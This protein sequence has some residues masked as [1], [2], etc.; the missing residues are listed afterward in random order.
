MKVSVS[1]LNIQK[2]TELIVMSGTSLKELP[3]PWRPGPSDRVRIN[4]ERVDQF[5]T[6]VLIEGDNVAYHTP[7]GFDHVL[8]HLTKEAQQRDATAS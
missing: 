8:E 6:P 4:G 2:S 7:A 1:N 3:T 5:P